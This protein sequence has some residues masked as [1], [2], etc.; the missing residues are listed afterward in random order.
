[1]QRLVTQILLPSTCAMSQDPDHMEYLYIFPH[2]IVE[3][4][5]AKK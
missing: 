2:E 5:F 3:L 1:M 4:C